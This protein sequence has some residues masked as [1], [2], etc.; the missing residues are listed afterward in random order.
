MKVSLTLKEHCFSDDIF[1]N[2][3]RQYCEFLPFDKS[4]KLSWVRF[5]INCP[6]IRIVR[7]Q[8]ALGPLGNIYWFLKKFLVQLLTLFLLPPSNR[9]SL[10]QGQCHPHSQSVLYIPDRVA[11]V[12]DIED[13]CFSLT[14]SRPR[15]GFSLSDL[16]VFSEFSRS[17]FWVFSEFALSMLRVVLSCIKLVVMIWS[18]YWTN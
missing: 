17:N 5:A 16:L 10:L 11:N 18:K 2:Q 1:K 12:R 15:P 8:A 4:S 3:I 13:V 6:L 14:N 7:V 9:I